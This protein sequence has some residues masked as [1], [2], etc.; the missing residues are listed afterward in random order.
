MSR[1]KKTLSVLTVIGLLAVV[2]VGV[3]FTQD[4]TP[5]MLK[6]RAQFG[7]FGRRIGNLL[8]RDAFKDTLANTLGISVDELVDAL[9]AGETPLSLAEQYDVSA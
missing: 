7:S 8:N 2:A 4:E 5:Q 3:V 1:M 6:E 9:A